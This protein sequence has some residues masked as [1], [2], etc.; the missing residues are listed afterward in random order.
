MVEHTGIRCPYVRLE[1]TVQHPD[2]TPVEVEGLDI[3]V[4]NSGSEASLFERSGDG[5]HGGLRCQTGHA[6]WELA[7]IKKLYLRPPTVNSNIHNI[8]P[9]SRSGEH[10]RSGDA[11][12]IV[13]VD[14]DR[15]IRILLTDCADQ[16]VE[17]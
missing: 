3:S 2:L 15:K 17:W 10:C 11:G 8:R 7:G 16:T 5:T 13:R 12:G 14:V 6:L 4:S 9:C 1:A